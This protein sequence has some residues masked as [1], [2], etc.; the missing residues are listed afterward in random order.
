MRLRPWLAALARAD[1]PIRDLDRCRLLGI[2]AYDL[3]DELARGPARAAAWNAYVLATYGDKLLAASP[4]GRVRADTADLAETLFRLAGVWVERARAI[5]D[6]PSHPAGVA[7]AE[8]LPHWHTPVRSQEELV[9]MR[10]PLETLRIH[11]AFDLQSISGDD[12][13]LP[14]LREQLAAIDAKVETV[15]GLWIARAPAEL[16]GGIGTEL[17]SGLDRAY[18]LG[19]ELAGL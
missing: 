4:T 13:A 1:V 10:E 17:A 12:G 2:G 18:A 3:I 7:L 9:G 14:R 6:D 19:R 5:A 16:R 8:P 15:D 11:I